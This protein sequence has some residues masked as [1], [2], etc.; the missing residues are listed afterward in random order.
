MLYIHSN[1]KKP[2]RHWMSFSCQKIDVNRFFFLIFKKQTYKCYFQFGNQS[3]IS[4][5]NTAL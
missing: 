1:L 3:H 5:K 4:D 2:S